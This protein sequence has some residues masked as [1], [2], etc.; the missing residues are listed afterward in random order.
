METSVINY[1]GKKTYSQWVG[2]ESEAKQ[3][4][5]VISHAKFLKI[6]S[7]RSI[8][9]NNRKESEIKAADISRLA[10]IKHYQGI[11]LPMV[12]LITLT[13]T[14]EVLPIEGKTLADITKVAKEV[15]EKWSK[16]IEFRK[17]VKGTGLCQSDI[18]VRCPVRIDYLD[19]GQLLSNS[20]SRLYHSVSQTNMV[21][22][23]SMLEALI[24]EDVP[25]LPFAT[26]QAK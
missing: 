24:G 15:S 6:K 19:K 10:A 12:V 23:P 4:E 1:E 9:R 20:V 14:G 21:S 11:K 13:S 8:D 16:I 22:L 18:L 17:T 2:I 7:E 3:G 26:F 5:K 25:S